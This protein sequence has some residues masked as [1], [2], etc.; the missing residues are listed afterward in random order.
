MVGTAYWTNKKNGEIAA[1]ANRKAKGIEKKIRG[2]KAAQAEIKVLKKN[3][4]KHSEG[5][6]RQLGWLRA[7]APANYSRFS[8]A[9]KQEIGALINNV[10]ALSS[11]L[12]KKVR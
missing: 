11:L 4:R 5:A 10:Q 6:L 7:N 12:H 2:L 3:S 1:N 8:Q 9:Q